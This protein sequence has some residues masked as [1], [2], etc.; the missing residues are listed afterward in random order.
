MCFLL[1]LSNIAK[2]FWIAVYLLSPIQL[3][4]LFNALFLG[5]STIESEKSE[6][7][8]LVDGFRVEQRVK[9]DVIN[10]GGFGLLESTT[11]CNGAVHSKFALRL[12]RR[13]TTDTSSSSSSSVGHIDTMADRLDIVCSRELTPIAAASSSTK[14]DVATDIV[15][16]AMLCVSTLYLPMYESLDAALLH[17][18]NIL[19][20]NGSS[21][22]YAFT[23]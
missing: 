23:A 17:L 4:R 21:C 10:T 2:W 9:M 5:T 15:T 20:E 8:P 16:S 13:P 1:K 12:R 14:I 11:Y 7:I 6:N 22:K 19:P 18:R 3:Q